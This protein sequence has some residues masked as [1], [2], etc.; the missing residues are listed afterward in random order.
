MKSRYE[1]GNAA[2]T[3]EQL[4]EHISRLMAEAEAM[5]AGPVTAEQ[6]TTR[7]EVVSP[8]GIPE[9]DHLGVGGPV[10]S[11]VARVEAAADDFSRVE[12]GDDTRDRRL[13]QLDC[14]TGANGDEGRWVVHLQG[15]GG[16]SSEAECK[17]RW[18]GSGFYT[19]AN[20]SNDWD[21]DGVPDR[22]EQAWSGGISSPL[23]ANDFATWNHVYV[24]YCSSDLWVGRAD[25]VALGSFTVHARGHAILHAVR[26]MLRKNNPNIGW[27]AADG[28]EIADIDS[29]DEILLSGTSAG[30]Y[31]VLQNGDWF[32]NVFQDKRTAI[33]S[34]AAIDV[35]PAVLT[36]F[37]VTEKLSNTS[38]AS[39]RLA[40]YETHWQP[41]GYWHAIDGY[42]DTT[43]RNNHSLAECSSPSLLLTLDANGDR[44][45][46]TPVFLRLDLE[47]GVLSDWIIG[48][49]GTP[50]NPD[51]HIVEI[52]LPGVQ[53][54]LQ[55]YTE[56]MRETMVLLVAD[57]TAHTS[58]FAPRC[59]K[60]VGLE[61]D[62]AFG[63]WTTQDTTDTPDPVPR[64]PASTVEDA[65]LEWFDPGGTLFL[66]Q[67]YIDTDSLPKADGSTVKF[68][69]CP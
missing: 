24:P 5:L 54:T 49:A 20:M 15:G 41:G 3:P 53:P 58:V 35:H 18:C 14:R 42:V 34:D 16:C 36:S 33:L 31:G 63:S 66:G 12:I 57:V 17:D 25:D 23:P 59:G 22:P 37:G 13:A 4:I 7:L 1:T 38:Y 67:R 26:M 27:Q 2:E 43:C 21:R 44:L 30:G 65:V 6:E 52:G 64:G 56:M 29:A 50:I 32:F 69:T 47:D 40:L 62:N 46:E 61:G 28:N 11:G 51:G 45:I 9:G 60:H 68:S 19:A 48:H 55:D 39:A 8:R 10:A